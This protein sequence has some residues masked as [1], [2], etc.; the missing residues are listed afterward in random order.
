MCVKEFFGYNCGHCSI[1]YL[2]KC[3][4]SL[5]N[6][7]FP[8]C[9]Y[10]AERPIFTDEYCHPCSRVVWNLKVLKEEEE[11]RGRH[12]R[13]ECFCETVFEREERSRRTRPRPGKGKGKA[14]SGGQT[15][16]PRDVEEGGTASANTVRETGQGHPHQDR[17][18]PALV[19]A[20][21]YVGYYI[22]QSSVQMTDPNQSYA[23]VVGGYG[24]EEQLVIGQAGAGMKWYPYSTS[25]P[26]Q[27]TPPLQTSPKAS[28]AMSVPTTGSPDQWSSEHDYGEDTEQ[29]QP[30]VV[31]SD[32]ARRD[33]A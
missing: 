8:I 14:I 3:P 5:S 29:Q 23:M 31:S 27:H 1:P 12:L 19:A 28:R 13:G 24:L 7:S 4:V 17:G 22:E 10:P 25:A 32:M 11:H 15:S 21:E 6:P 33:S 30:M 16:G 18:D 20:Y 26:P 2:R 9:E